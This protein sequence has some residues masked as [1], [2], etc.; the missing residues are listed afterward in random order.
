MDALL[1]ERET[2]M[3]DLTRRQFALL[4]GAGVAAGNFARAQAKL[5]AGEVVDRVK[6]NL[7]IPW[8]NSSYRDTFKIGG[9]E[10]PVTGIVSTFMSTLS[11]LQRSVAAG[12]TMVITHEPTFWS[13]RD[14]V[15]VLQGDPLYKFK[16]DYANAHGL[17]VWRIHDH[18]HARVP[19]GIQTGWNK[20]MGWVQYQVNGSLTRWNLP[21]TT[22]GELA[23]YVAKTLE[24]RSVRVMGDPNL[25]V[26][27]VGRGSHTLDGNMAVLPGVDCLLVSEAR[28]YES[29]EYVRDAILS[30]EKKGAI[31]ISHEAGEEAGMDEFAAWIKPLVAEVP[32]QF[33]PTRDVFWNV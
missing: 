11:V 26:V 9:P 2:T 13:D 21:P 31:F 15:A 12:A 19:D 5:T 30:G 33:I 4:A 22:L 32:V 14:T 24:S 20:R 27:S 23:K 8:D 16:L 25:R 3:T 10:T 6:K 29:Y 7:G 18:W 1:S 28:E 17:A